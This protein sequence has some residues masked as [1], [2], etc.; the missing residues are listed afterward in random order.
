MDVLLYEAGGCGKERCIWHPDQDSSVFPLLLATKDGRY[1]RLREPVNSQSEF[2]PQ[3]AL[4]YLP[5]TFDTGN[6]SRI[7]EHI[8]SSLGEQLKPGMRGRL[9]ATLERIQ[10]DSDRTTGELNR[11]RAKIDQLE[12]ELRTAKSSTGDEFPAGH[13]FR[14]FGRILRS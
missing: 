11:A 9:L 14:P 3:D 4:V 2:K 12:I 7:I 10:E 5:E 6:P 8:V 13:V 1:Y